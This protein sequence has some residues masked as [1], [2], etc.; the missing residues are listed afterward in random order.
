MSIRLGGAI[1]IGAFAFGLA[2]TSA[3]AGAACN[4][5]SACKS[6]C[7]SGEGLACR[8]LGRLYAEGD[9]VAPDHAAAAEAWT[10]GCDTR[11]G[12]TTA[13]RDG[14][15]CYQLSVLLRQGW[16]LEV[17]RD[18]QASD[19]R[20]ATALEVAIPA[21]DDG[22]G[23]ACYTVALA[24]RERLELD[25]WPKDQTE[26]GADVLARSKKA[27]DKGVVDACVFARR[28]LWPLAN[29]ELVTGD[30][31]N[32]V[33]EGATKKLIDICKDGNATACYEAAGSVSDDKQA[34]TITAAIDKACEAGKPK[35]CLGR[36]LILVSSVKTPKADDPVVQEAIKLIQESCLQTPETL[37]VEFAQAMIADT[38]LEELGAHDPDKG[39]KIL[40]YQCGRGQREACFA[41]GKT[42]LADKRKD[43]E[44]LLDRSCRLTEPIDGTGNERSCE[45]CDEVGT[46]PE[47]KRRET[48][49]IGAQCA[50]G[51]VEMCEVLG[52]RYGAGVGVEVSAKKSAQSFKY[53]CDASIKSACGKL[54]DLCH[55]DDTIGIELCAPSLLQTDVFYEAEWQLRTN[56]KATLA[57][58][59]EGDTAKTS[60][61]L[62]GAATASGGITVQRGK[63]DADLVVSVVLDRARQAAVKLVVE[64]LESKMHDHKLRTYMR[65]LLQQG[66]KLLA[67]T[68][69]LRRDALQDLGMT[70]VRAFAASNLIRTVLGDADGLKEAPGVGAI[71]AT[72]EQ[73]WLTTADG[74]IAP[75]L[76]GYLADLAYWALGGEALFQ[77]EGAAD[78]PAPVCPFK[79]KRKDLCAALT[80]RDQV[81]VSL[82]I[83]GVLTALNM[84]RALGS[85]G[86]I[87]VRR[88][89]EAI[90]QSTSIVDFASTP[91]LNINQWQVRIVGD[92]RKRFG[93][94]HERLSEL[95]SLITM[96]TYEADGPDLM[97]L[98]RQAKNA[99]IFLRTDDARSLLL[100]GLSSQLAGL[101]AMDKFASK[102][103]TPP[104]GVDQLA[105]T[106]VA[107]LAAL[108]KLGKTD[109]SA[110]SKQLTLIIGRFEK[111]TATLEEL[112][113]DIVAIRS[114]LE[115]HQ[116]MGTDVK[117]H[118]AI[119]E[120]PLGDLDEL[121]TVFPKVVVV[122]D[123][124]D[125]GV[126]DVLPGVDLRGVRFARSSVVRL[127][128][129]LDLMSQV[130]RSVR[131]TKTVKQV[132]DTLA[133]LGRWK[134]GEFTAP[135]YDMLQPVIDVIETR[136]PM[137][138][139]QLFAI[140]GRVRLDSLVTS[141]IHDDPCSNQ[142]RAECWVFKIA[143]SLQEAIT[144]D[145]DSIR[146][147]GAEVA[148]R[149]ARFGDDFRRREKS[150]WY[151]HLTV[152]MGS[153]WSPPPEAGA[154]MDDARF[155]PL[156]SEQIGFGWATPTFWDDR[157]TFKAGIAASGILYRMLLDN[158]ES[159][160]V[161]GNAFVAVDI[162]DLIEVY[163]AATVL[164]YPPTETSDAHVAPGVSFGLSVPLSAY[165][166][167]L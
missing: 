145:G 48:W 102:G 154:T 14:R 47:C 112:G 55:A 75:E 150:R 129:F 80:T 135:L 108:D 128:G 35:A 153:L 131:Q 144:R 134:D 28:E 56:A 85:A 49:K 43:A 87:D 5:E 3:H 25:T 39:V 89:I 53:A 81:T 103:L 13:P 132:I 92:F 82:R 93:T 76:E 120:L 117:L 151:F 60:V 23:D 137:P 70:L 54:D 146:I 36:A 90:A 20:L 138:L 143:Y 136:N 66:A 1:A 57:T 148:K 84:V 126:R 30:Q 31:L 121:L 91:G 167:R 68:T 11:A 106:R 21:C 142:N 123:E 122:L 152:G 71:F 74:S 64:E 59:A 147:D 24:E 141:L 166:D 33:L 86:G 157:L 164:A 158:A 40:K 78:E 124:L 32:G 51:N 4:S 101:L 133:L 79:D 113:R 45:A 17:E 42:L 97:T 16:G 41:A 8:E 7:D 37:C 127:L 46:L 52:E 111:V 77:R 6:A 116:A 118:L 119:D 69:S 100:D 62:G 10:K 72:W 2:S 88:L 61:S 29:A 67:D 44:K 130:A 63:L 73:P 95:R 34:K 110:L 149:L 140:V 114:A 163:G 38:Q 160:A 22:G 156:I 125:A 9:G 26:R 27:C 139:E 83:D 18:A 109:R 50:S 161:M 155:T 104:P 162:Y 94:V 99:K 65:D 165:L 15:S 58:G 98:A 12:G 115:H 159:N 105:E 107:A 96:K 19:D